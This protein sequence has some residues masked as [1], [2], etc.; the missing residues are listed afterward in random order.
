MSELVL[1]ELESVGR[2]MWRVSIGRGIRDVVILFRELESFTKETLLCEGHRSTA[3]QAKCLLWFGSDLEYSRL[4]S[5]LLHMTSLSN[6]K[7]GSIS[8]T[9]VAHTSIL[10]PFLLKLRIL[11]DERLPEFQPSRICRD[12]AWAGTGR[13]IAPVDYIPLRLALVILLR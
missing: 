9:Q 5:G 1:G 13:M 4:V 12:S 6:L 7:Q 2:G 3:S 10:L 8:I 11:V